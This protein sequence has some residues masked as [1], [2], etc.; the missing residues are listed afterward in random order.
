MTVLIKETKPNSADFVW[1]ERFTAVGPTRERIIYRKSAG[2][3]FDFVA[4]EPLFSDKAG[5]VIIIKDASG[6][7]EAITSEE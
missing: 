7:P 3:P 4:W 2:T 6:V 5:N 1:I